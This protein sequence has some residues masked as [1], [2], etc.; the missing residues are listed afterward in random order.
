MGAK[1]IV[2]SGSPSSPLAKLSDIFLEA[3][4]G[5]EGG[6]LGL[7]PRNS[8]LAEIYVLAGLSV[9]LQSKKK[10][11]RKEYYRRHPA[12]ALGRKSR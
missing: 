6:Q 12:G 11:S 1:L 8:V 10:F 4:V 5:N 2:V 3:R 7:A 9:A